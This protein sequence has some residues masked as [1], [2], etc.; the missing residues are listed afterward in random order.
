VNGILHGGRLDAAVAEFGGKPADWLD[1]ST[2]IN[3]RSYPVPT[4][5]QETWSRLPDH[6]AYTR[7][8]GAARRYYHVRNQTEIV[9]AGGTQ[10]IIQA[11]PFLYPQDCIGI[12]GPTYEEHAHCWKLAGHKVIET[13][14]LELPDDARHLLV[15]NPNNPTACVSSVSELS[16][17]AQRLEDRGGTLIVDE[18]FAD[19]DPSLSLVPEL[20]DNAVVLRSFGKFFGLAGVRLGFAICNG[21]LARKLE[22]RLGPWNVSGPA[23]AVGVEALCDNEWIASSKRWIR[24]MAAKQANTLVEAELDVVG[25]AGLFLYVRSQRGPEIY[26]KLLKEKILTRAFEKQPDYLRFGLCGDGRQLKRLQ[27]ALAKAVR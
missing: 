13:D 16:A 7:L 4:L 3:P 21:D 11:L 2:G 22:S 24:E 25:N 20:P 9:P 15:V 23:L 19:V 8:I 18:A 5:S 26:R 6:E 27:Q 14:G 10:A 1:L 12:A 17:L